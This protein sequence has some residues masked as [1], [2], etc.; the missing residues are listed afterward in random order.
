MVDGGDLEVGGVDVG[1]MEDP[2]TCTVE[3]EYF[4]PNYTRVRGPVM[5]TVFVIRE[6]PRIACRLSEIQAAKIQYAI[7][8]TDLSSDASSEWI[9]STPGRIA[10]ASHNTVIFS[11][12][13]A[14]GLGFAFSV[15]NALGSEGFEVEFPDEESTRIPVTFEGHY[16]PAAAT[17]APW[18]ITNTTAS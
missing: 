10:A 9:G 5:G 12:T 13:K 2:V 16:D 14:S 18:T 7:P 11:T 1:A 6:V 3:R 4:K 15:H 8:G 17:T